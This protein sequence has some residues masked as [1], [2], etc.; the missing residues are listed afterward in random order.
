MPTQQRLSRVLGLP[1]AV[2]LGLGAM[3]GTGIYVST[4]LAVEAASWLALPALVI[5]ALLAMANGLSS[6]R[7]AARH[8]VSGGA[9]EYGYVFLG[10]WPGFLAGW[11][12]VIAKAASAGAA[13][14]SFAAY[15]GAIT[16]TD[17]WQPG[18]AVL[19]VVIVTL[20]V[21][22]G[23]R[24]SVIANGLM[25]GVS[26]L[27][28]LSLLAC[29]LP[30]VEPATPTPDVKTRSMLEAAAMLFV[31]FTG[32]GRIATLGEEVKSPRSTIPR[33]I[34]A[35]II[36]AGVLCLLV[37]ISI[38]GN[39]MPATAGGAARDGELLARL[40]ASLG[41]PRIAM[42]VSC[43]ALFAL[44]GVLLNLVLG[45]SR[46]L[47]AMARRGELPGR[48]AVIDEG[49]NS[50][51]MATLLAGV[52]IVLVVMR[53]SVFLAWSLSAFTVLLYYAITNLAALKIARTRA[54]AMVSMLG[55]AGCLA[56]APF[57]DAAAWRD[58]F[59][60]LVAGAGWHFVARH[61][62][63]IRNP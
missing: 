5:A 56:L 7:L 19:L 54:K 42:L 23:L 44:V 60:L 55:L 22:L 10:H 43:G 62:S 32:Y 40:A 21:L 51:P 30:T 1:G 35:T 13:A 17:A 3:L 53:G 34:V 57:V 47:L 59:L 39:M 16:G 50:A 33:A 48:L 49:G 63:L 25:V 31:A 26:L 58:G 36:I 45:I 46:V 12:F 18:V 8:P 29:A 27:A 41:H 15:L 14:L 24:Q 4:G 11:L 2:L 20:I 6:A 38:A 37:L 61:Y 28:L 9:Y 52:I